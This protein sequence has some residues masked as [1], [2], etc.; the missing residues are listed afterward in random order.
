MSAFTDR[1]Y[2][3]WARKNG[4]VLMLAGR[5][6]R[7]RGYGG[8]PPWERSETAPALSRSHGSANPAGL[9][10]DAGSGAQTEPKRF[11]AP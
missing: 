10:L 1:L 11:C 6:A 8:T 4:A 2:L 7:C 5:P 9:A 3:E